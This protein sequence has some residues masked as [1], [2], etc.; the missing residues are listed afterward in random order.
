MFYSFNVS[1]WNH[2]ILPV[3]Q[4]QDT[5]STPAKSK[6]TIPCPSRTQ[7]SNDP[8]STNPHNKYTPSGLQAPYPCKNQ[9]E[10]NL[11]KVHMA[12]ETTPARRV[13]VEW[14]DKH[15]LFQSRLTD[16]RDRSRRWWVIRIVCERAFDGSWC[17]D[18]RRSRFQSLTR[19]V[20]IRTLGVVSC[21]CP[22]SV[23][24]IRV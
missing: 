7:F 22:S 1:A 11:H 17:C 2:S 13:L 3:L 24:M 12:P 5:T 6:Y 15:T 9:T 4:V 21:P 19:I 23:R 14:A 10:D 20:R 16:R 18:N 8:P